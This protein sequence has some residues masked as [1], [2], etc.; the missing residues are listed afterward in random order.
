MGAAPASPVI[1]IVEDH[2]DSSAMYAEFL[3]AEGFVPRSALDA[4]EAFTVACD[5]RPDLVVTDVVLPRASGLELT[6]RLR[7]DHRTARIRIIVLTARAFPH[8]AFD[9]YQ[10]GC[11][12]FVTKP[13]LPDTLAREIRRVLTCPPRQLYENALDRIRAE[14]LEMPG[15][16]LKPEQVQRLCGVEADVCRPVLDALVGTGFLCVKADGSYARLTDGDGPSA[17]SASHH[18]G[19]TLLKGRAESSKGVRA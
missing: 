5:L 8:D 18:T 7:R 17:S 1:L 16:H 19:R 14:Y 15:M 13:C 9:A 10:A 4:D 12:S 3:A 2:A 11:D 6:R